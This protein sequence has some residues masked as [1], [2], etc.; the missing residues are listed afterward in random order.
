M[1]YY[2]VIVGFEMSEP[3]VTVEEED[4]AVSL[5]LSILD[6]RAAISLQVSLPLTLVLRKEGD[7]QGKGIYCY[8]LSLQKRVDRNPILTLYIACI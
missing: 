7:S 6:P 2:A 1:Y 4:T 3:L 5:D 8:R